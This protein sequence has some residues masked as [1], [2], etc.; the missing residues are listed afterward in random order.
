MDGIFETND[1]SQIKVD[2]IMGEP[3]Y[4]MDHFYRNPE[5][6][7]S[8]I[9]THEAELW[10]KHQTPT[11]NGVKFFDMRHTLECPGLVGIQK[12]LSALVRQEPLNPGVLTTNQS[13]FIRDGFNDFKNNYWWPHLDNGYTALIYLNRETFPGTNLYEPSDDSYEGVTEHL[14]PWRSKEKWKLMGNFEA[15]YNRLVLFNA[16]EL[17]HGMAVDNDL[18]F[19]DKFRLNQAIFFDAERPF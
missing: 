2:R 12:K 13:R 3:V 8:W 19:G 1:L 9:Q 10:K 5:K 14:A 6:V 15:S 7:I 18:F 11:Y 17:F 4:T 16:S